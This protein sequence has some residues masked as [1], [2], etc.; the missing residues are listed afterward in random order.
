M[1]RVLVATVVHHPL[2]ARV[3]S[4]EI[5]AILAA[6]HQVTYAAPWTAFGIDPPPEVDHID[7]RRAYRWDRGRALWSARRALRRAAMRHD[8]LLIHNPELLLALPG[9]PRPPT[10]WDV[11]E[12][13]DASLIDKTYLPRALVAPASWIVRRIEHLAERRIHLLLAEHGYQDRFD[14]THPV[15]P[16]EAEAPEE[17]L[18]PGG[19]RAV[20]LGRVSHGRGGA[21][22]LA[23]TELLPAS[24]T[25]EVLGWAEPEITAEL[26]RAA[27]EGTVRWEGRVDNALALQRLQGAT[28]GLSLLHD[29]PNYRHSRPT[30]IVEYMAQ[31]VPVVTTPSPVAVEIV[32]RHQCGIVVPFGDPGAAADAVTRLAEDAD[33]RAKLASNGRRAALEHYDW[34]RSGPAFVRHLE[35]WAQASA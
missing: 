8:I 32:E 31:G 9:V 30:K 13:V 2:D 34:R 1:M 5:G 17:V 26:E 4:R 14:R 10:V 20:Y 15:V 12:D 28:A 11:H 18:P 19:D 23:L 16:N 6:G 33:L 21:E 35:R 25:L 22:L 24:V 7:L 27:S 3:W 29:L